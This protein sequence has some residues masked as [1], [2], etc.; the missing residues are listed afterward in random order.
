MSKN[1]RT[2]APSADEPSLDLSKRLRDSKISDDGDKYKKQGTTVKT[3][4]K[5]TAKSTAREKEP[6]RR[7]SK[8]EKTK[9][10]HSRRETSRHDPLRESSRQGSSKG[11]TLTEQPSSHYP[12]ARLPRVSESTI[13][14]GGRTVHMSRVDE[15]SEPPRHKSSTTSRPMTKSKAPSH[16][17]SIFQTPDDAK[18]ASRQTKISSLDPYERQK[19]EQWAQEQIRLIGACPAKLGWLRVEQYKYYRCT[20][21][22]HII[23]DESLAEGKGGM[24]MLPAEMFPEDYDESVLWG[25][26]YPGPDAPL[27]DK[28]PGYIALR[29]SMR[30]DEPTRYYSGP[31][32]KPYLA[33]DWF[34]GI[35]AEFK[36]QREEMAAYNKRM[37]R[38]QLMV[39]NGQQLIAGGGQQLIVGGGPLIVGSSQQL[40]VGHSQQF[41]VAGMMSHHSYHS[42]G[43]P[44]RHPGQ[45]PGALSPY[46][47]LSP[48]L[49]PPGGGQCSRRR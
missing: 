49:K 37:K 30:G 44:F 28:D 4:A 20:G 36:D 34:T 14:S 3:T 2:K 5:I 43:C 38:Q 9:H 48:H 41:V 12:V 6:S 1:S 31:K 7:D 15:R 16:V 22:N 27:R 18:M 21:G 26:Y 11:T 24:Y 13:E 42:R 35:H 23:T 10:E 33:P 39:A 46:G 25:P 17:K 47:Q 32:P 29:L 40:I 45:F 19:Q 8:H